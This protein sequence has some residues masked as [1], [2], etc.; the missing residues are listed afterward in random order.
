MGPKSISDAL[1][2]FAPVDEGDPCL[3]C[4]VELIDS[5]FMVCGH[6]C[7][8]DCIEEWLRRSVL[9]PMCKKMQ[10][11][12]GCGHP[13]PPV[14]PKEAS[15]AI[16]DLC[17]KCYIDTLSF[18]DAA[19]NEWSLS[20]WS[21]ARLQ[22]LD[23]YTPAQKLRVAEEEKLEVPPL[24]TIPFVEILSF[25]FTSVFAS[26]ILRKVVNDEDWP[27]IDDQTYEPCIICKK[28]LNPFDDPK[29]FTSFGRVYHRPSHR[30]PSGIE[31][32]MGVITGLPCHHYLH[33]KCIA[34]AWDLFADVPNK[35]PK[36]GC[37]Q[38][39]TPYRIIWMFDS[40]PMIL[41]GLGDA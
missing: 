25:N 28:Q 13:Y 32:H 8:K 20:E 27:R 22:G 35:E 11:H 5:R 10:H 15:K 36:K 40:G 33:L 41:G 3:I 2:N 4:Q 24:G 38:C 21:P 26:A 29:P 6:I 31:K 1:Q 37:P 30:R 17:K 39:D 7:C 16:P 19:A 34:S 18:S 14:P 9:C 12:P 23:F